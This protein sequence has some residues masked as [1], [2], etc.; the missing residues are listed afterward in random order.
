MILALSLALRGIGFDSDD[1]SE[2]LGL[3]V[4]FPQSAFVIKM[5]DF[6][7]TSMSRYA[8]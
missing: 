4:Q 2:I 1:E 6:A 5:A 3:G 8:V 7:H